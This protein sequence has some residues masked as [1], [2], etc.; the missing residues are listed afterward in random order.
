MASATINFRPRG[1][2]VLSAFAGATRPWSA[3]CGSAV[4]RPTR[5]GDTPDEIRLL[6]AA[7]SD[8]R[9]DALERLASSICHQG[10]VY[11]ASAAAVP[12]L[13]R[14]ALDPTQ[15]DRSGIVRLLAMVARG[16]TDPSTAATVGR[17]ILDAIAPFVD[18]LLTSADTAS[19]L[20]RAVAE[21]A[22]ALQA[23]KPDD[24]WP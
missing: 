5:T 21:L 1:Q 11:P 3:A 17:V 2:F 12:F 8:L 15:P 22:D 9:K 7:D 13:A 14:L 18:A 10:S 23:N 20:G 24:R 19:D 16:A 4:D 6:R